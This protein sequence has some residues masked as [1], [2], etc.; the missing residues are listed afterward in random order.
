MTIAKLL[1]SGKAAD[2]ALLNEEDRRLYTELAALL[3]YGWQRVDKIRAAQ[4]VMAERRSRRP[5]AD[6]NSAWDRLRN[7]RAL[8]GIYA[9]AWDSVSKV[10]LFLETVHKHP[11]TGMSLVSHVRLDSAVGRE[12]LLTALT[13]S[14]DV[15]VGEMLAQA[16]GTQRL[17]DPRKRS[18]PAALVSKKFQKSGTGPLGS[19]AIHWKEHIRRR[20]VYTPPPDDANPGQGTTL[21]SLYPLLTHGDVNAVRLALA[22][23]T[24]FEHDLEL[25]RWFAAGRPATSS[26]F[27]ALIHGDLRWWDV[28]KVVLTYWDQ[29]SKQQAQQDRGWLRAF[30]SEYGLSFRVL[31]EAVA[32]AGAAGVGSGQESAQPV[33]TVL[34]GGDGQPVGQ[35]YT[36]LSQRPPGGSSCLVTHRVFQ[37]DLTPRRDRGRRYMLRTYQPPWS[38]AGSSPFFVM[39]QGGPDRITVQ[40][41]DG[42]TTEL[43]PGKFTDLLV[44][45][46]ALKQAPPGTPVVLLVPFGGG[47]GLD[48]PRLVAAKTGR[49]VWSASGPLDTL[50]G[51]NDSVRRITQFRPANWVEPVGHWILSRP[52]DLERPDRPG[53]RTAPSTT[54]TRTVDGDAIPDTDIVT[55][56]IIGQDHRSVGRSS[57]TPADQATRESYQKE[58]AGRDRYSRGGAT[59]T[60]GTLERLPGSE[61]GVPWAADTAAGRTPYFFAAHGK[62]ETVTLQGAG[63]RYIE[64]AGSELGGYLRRRPS[65]S[66]LDPHHPIVLI[67]CSTGKTSPGSDS[68]VAQHV[69][70][71]TGRVVYAPNTDTTDELT[72]ETGSDGLSGSWVRF[73][74]RT[75]KSGLLA[76]FTAKLSGRRTP[77]DAPV[78]PFP[79]SSRPARALPTNSPATPQTTTPPT[80]SPTADSRQNRAKHVG[81]EPAIAPHLPDTPPNRK[82]GRGVEDLLES[83]RPHRGGTEGPARPADGAQSCRQNHRQDAGTRPGP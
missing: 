50:P 34:T 69:A 28:E 39:A 7:T 61:R 25:R 68:P 81:T 24:Q 32:A 15:A 13:A 72:V 30:A 75:Q 8:V 57:H 20:T 65:L 48:L 67:S 33:S 42:T 60:D 22:E 16:A 43:S 73:K 66:L 51:D 9:T 23:A 76:S 82:G 46:P 63:E 62:P 56:T 3:G 31:L 71:T 38:A 78:P 80:P 37:A 79:A 77:A 1:V 2:A 45:D 12:S 35:D 29:D 83:D 19:T 40:R 55:H 26:H 17:T 49:E 18:L 27:G 21:S 70:D 5:D 41:G 58:L 54:M 10:I 4:L 11:G 74:P 52:V 47:H 44:K 6:R 36:P 64:V 53:S 14:P 59:T